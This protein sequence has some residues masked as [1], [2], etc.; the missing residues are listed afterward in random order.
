MANWANWARC[1][2]L[3]KICTQDHWR[4]R[5]KRERPF[6]GHYSIWLNRAL[7]NRLSC[8]NVLAMFTECPERM[9]P[10]PI[11]VAWNRWRTSS[12]CELHSAKFTLWIAQCVPSS[13]IIASVMCSQLN[14]AV[15]LISL[16]SCSDLMEHHQKNRHTVENVHW[17][18]KNSYENAFTPWTWYDL[19]R[20]YVAA[21]R[22]SSTSF[23][24][25]VF[26]TF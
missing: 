25:L 10:K 21:R 13:I 11:E 17:C 2:K 26:S 24:I 6:I 7:P 22:C 9:A 5:V 20:I 16:A 18:L 4:A 19:I 14:A 23:L 12:N 8:S 15:S 1:V 3:C